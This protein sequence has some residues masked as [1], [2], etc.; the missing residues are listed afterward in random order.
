[1]RAPALNVAPQSLKYIPTSLA[2][3]D[4]KT[5]REGMSRVA[6]A[7]HVVTTGSGAAMAGVTATAVCSV[8]DSPPM[9][10][11]CLHRQGRL[12]KLLRQGSPI[13]VNTLKAG[14]EEL[15]AIFAGVG[16]IPMQERFAG[17]DWVIQRDTA[18]VLSDAVVSFQCRVQSLIEAG[19]H[20]IVACQ[21]TDV[22]VGNSSEAL[23][24]GA[25]RYAHV[26]LSV[27]K[28]H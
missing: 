5:F 15:A 25:R 22:Y 24:Y 20:S 2:G 3:M 23:V 14:H 13:A 19:S 27:A 12:H 26:D 6:G 16:D 10:L 1:M 7:V 11:V 28:G 21:V 8:S 4:A 18:P 9:V 17:S